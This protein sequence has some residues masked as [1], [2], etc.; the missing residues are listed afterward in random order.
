MTANHRPDVMT[1]PR[2]GRML[3]ADGKSHVRRSTCRR[4]IIKDWLWK[5]SECGA[6]WDYGNLFNYCPNCGRRI[7]DGKDR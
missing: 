6:R 3:D 4:I 2:D 7:E 1:A 5:C